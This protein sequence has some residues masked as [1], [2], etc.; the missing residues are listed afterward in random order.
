MLC[1][2]DECVH[3]LKYFYNKALCMGFDFL[4]YLDS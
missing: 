3:V 1:D 2:I 4:L